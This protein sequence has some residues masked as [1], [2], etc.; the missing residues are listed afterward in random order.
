[1]GHLQI[2]SE[3]AIL[4]GIYADM[5]DWTDNDSLLWVFIY[6]P[7]T[8]VMMFIIVWAQHLRYRGMFGFGTT[9]FYGL[10]GFTA[11]HIPGIKYNDCPCL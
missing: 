5:V 6:E 4:S 10:S 1:M 7:R 11:A 3:V 8:W 2:D 9:A